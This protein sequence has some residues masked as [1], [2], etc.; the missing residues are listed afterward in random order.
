MLEFLFR[1]R[2]TILYRHG[3]TK[4][5]LNIIYPFT[6]TNHPQPAGGSYNRVTNTPSTAAIPS[7]AK[8]LCLVANALAA[9]VKEAVAPVSVPEG[10]VPAEPVGALPSAPP[11]VAPTDGDTFSEACAA[12]LVKLSIVRDLFCAGLF[13]GMCEQVDSVDED[14]GAEDLRVDH[15]HHASLAMFPL[16]AVIP[17]GFGV[18]DQNGIRR[19]CRGIGLDRHESREKARNRSIDVIDGNTGLVECRLH[20]RVILELVSHSRADWV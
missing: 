16:R 14:K 9:P 3:C 6:F 17:D 12:S 19:S 10:T 20:N 13:W 8:V 18:I 7:M 2:N 15:S 4:P 11:E 5:L 1:L